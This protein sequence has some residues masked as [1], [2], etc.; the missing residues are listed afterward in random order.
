MKTQPSVPNLF[1]QVLKTK[2]KAPRKI[3]DPSSTGAPLYDHE[4]ESI[5]LISNCFHTQ[6]GKCYLSL[7][8]NITLYQGYVVWVSL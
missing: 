4:R 2:Q 1:L 5:P 7:E 6:N 8:K 3:Q